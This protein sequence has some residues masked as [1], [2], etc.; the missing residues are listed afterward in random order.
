MQEGRGT[1]KDT[2]KLWV[3]QQNLARFRSKTDSQCHLIPVLGTHQ[4][5]SSKQKQS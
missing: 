2:A 4:G 5:K 1:E 3:K